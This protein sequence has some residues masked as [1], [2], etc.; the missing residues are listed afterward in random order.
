MIHSYHLIMQWRGLVKVI[1]MSTFS[2]IIIFEEGSEKVNKINE[3]SQGFCNSSLRMTLLV[4]MIAVY[5]IRSG[6]SLQTQT[7][8]VQVCSSCLYRSPC[9]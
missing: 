2:F 6:T 9:L 1:N 3:K 7:S 4:E 5:F 8:I